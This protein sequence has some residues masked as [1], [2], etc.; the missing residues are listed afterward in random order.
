MS[1]YAFISPSQTWRPPVAVP[2]KPPA[3]QIVSEEE[4]WEYHAGREAWREAVMS[5]LQL[6]WRGATGLWKMINQVAAE[7]LAED[8]WELRENKKL[9]LRAVGQLVRERIVLRHRRRWIA[10][11]D[12]GHETIP[13]EEVPGNRLRRI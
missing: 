13:L 11:I 2:A 5:Y 10:L 9:I 6:N 4:T 3:R 8:R 12:V 7:S 1:I